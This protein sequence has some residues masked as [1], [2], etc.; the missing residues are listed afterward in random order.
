MM[1]LPN[2]PEI[3]EQ[4]LASIICIPGNIKRSIRLSPDDF[5]VKINAEIYNSILSIDSEGHNPD[6]VLIGEE[7]KKKG[8]LTPQNT[9]HL[10]RIADNASIAMDT[11][12]YSKNLRAYSDSRKIAIMCM[13]ILD[14]CEKMKDPS[15]IVKTAQEQIF[16]FS[17]SKNQDEFYDLKQLM[18]DAINRI[19]DAQTRDYEIGIKLGLPEIDKRSNIFGTKMIF[20]AARPGQGK[21]AL[22]IALSKHIAMQDRKPAILSIEMDKESIADRYLSAESNINS[23]L[24]HKKSKIELKDIDRLTQS[25]SDLSLLPIKINDSKANIIDV[26]RRIRRLHAEGY[27]PFFIDQ[28]SKI[29]FPRN[30]TEF[31]GYTRNCSAI[32]ELAKELNQQIFI[33]CQLG[34][35]VEDTA[36]KRP[37]M[38]HLKQTGQIEEDADMILFI[39]RPGKY[40][41]KRNTGEK[42]DESFTE[43]IMAKCR[44]GIPCSDSSPVFDV[45][46]GNFILNPFGGNGGY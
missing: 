35:A 28:L 29:S 39:Y 15:E 13:G 11:M 16:S 6:I 27:G 31:Q 23:L 14:N 4:F 30:L 1:I 22:M 10:T 25:A 40:G 43:I 26:K 9:K 36:L 37:E 33:L 5:Y 34:R 20:I 8:L 38:R 19:E 44:N 7:L 17:D 42:Y 21:T 41:L 46:T 2:S 3:E 12:A 24:F 32:S 18:H 45:K